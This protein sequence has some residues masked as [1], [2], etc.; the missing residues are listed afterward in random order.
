MKGGRFKGYLLNKD[1]DYRGDNP[2]FTKPQVHVVTPRKEASSG[3]VG[4]LHLESLSR[5][6]VGFQMSPSVI[7][8]SIRPGLQTAATRYAR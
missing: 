3:R 7:S 2:K 6:P 1:G 4:R 8:L 5:D